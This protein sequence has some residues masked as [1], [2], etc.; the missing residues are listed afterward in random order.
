MGQKSTLSC[1]EGMCERLCGVQNYAG[2]GWLREASNP[3]QYTPHRTSLFAMRNK[4][5]IVFS[6][7]PKAEGRPVGAMNETYYMSEVILPE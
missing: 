5:L 4:L 3:V 7:T 2:H 1:V 6:N